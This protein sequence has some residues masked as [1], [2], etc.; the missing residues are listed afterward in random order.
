MTRIESFFLQ[1]PAG[2]L[3]CMLKLP[4]PGAEGS[5]AAVICHPHPL[6][7]GTL[8]NKVVHAAAEA[9][10]AA[11]LPTLRF[12]FRGVGGSGGAHDNGRGEQ[13]DLQAVLDH[14]EARF[15]GRPLVLA[16]YSFGAYVALRVG[17]PF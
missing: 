16:G 14:V 6:F 3:E 11:G 13:G 10:V 1:G 5:G 9:L 17:C 2:R 15:P 8:H 4:A 12:N 7:G